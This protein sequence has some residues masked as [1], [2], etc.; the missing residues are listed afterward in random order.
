M[1]HIIN[2]SH[3]VEKLLLNLGD[4]MTT[5][6]QNIALEEAIKEQGTSNGKKADFSLALQHAGNLSVTLGELL[7]SVNQTFGVEKARY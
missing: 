3:R 6:G 5:V 1:D 7:R 4:T 2:F